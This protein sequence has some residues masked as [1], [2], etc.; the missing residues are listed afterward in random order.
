M[1]RLAAYSYDLNKYD[2]SEHEEGLGVGLLHH[3]CRK[4]NFLVE[5]PPIASSIV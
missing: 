3:F 1:I 2:F 5:E 4:P